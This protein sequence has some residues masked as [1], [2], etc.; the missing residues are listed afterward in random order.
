MISSQ[1]RVILVSGATG[2]GKST[3]IP[4]IILSHH[5][6]A[7]VV[8]TQPRRIAATGVAGRVAQEHG[9]AIGTTVGYAVKGDS[10]VSNGARAKWEGKD[11][12]TIPLK[13]FLTSLCAPR[14]LAGTPGYSS[15]QLG[16]CFGS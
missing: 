5:P 1:A 15:A 13:A 6:T 16:C 14:R 9:T 12:P 7:K 4:Q 8:V 10:K 11:H 3:Q 2:C